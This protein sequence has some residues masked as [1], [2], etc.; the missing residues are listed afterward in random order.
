VTAMTLV[1]PI[2]PGKQEAWRRFCQTLLGR[3]LCQYAESR[4]RL[5]ITKELIWLAQT[6]QGDL[7]V[8]YL[9]APH[10]EHVLVQLG[11]SDLP[12]DRWLRK[13]WQELHGLDLTQPPLG[14]EN[15]L[16]LVW[17]AS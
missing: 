7:A 4:G 5:G 17:P 11:A 3:R 6:P 9:E 10:P 8:V 14:P 16:V 15:E 13:Q 12:F 1:L 2:L